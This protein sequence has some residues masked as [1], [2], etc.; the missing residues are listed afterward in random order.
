MFVQDLEER[1]QQD[2]R[3]QQVEGYIPTFDDDED[4]SQYKFQKF[5]ATYF[6]GNAS[7]TYIRRSLKEPL[8]SLRNEGDQLVRYLAFFRPLHHTCR[9]D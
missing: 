9:R 7:H 4:I 6:Q 1:R 5:A 3:G 8:L 2:V